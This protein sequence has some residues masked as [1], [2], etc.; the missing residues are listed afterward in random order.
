[1][2]TEKPGWDAVVPSGATGAAFFR[3][4][5]TWAGVTAASDAGAVAKQ[6][7]T[8][9]TAQTGN[10]NLTGTVV[11]GTITPSLLRGFPTGAAGIVGTATLGAGTVTV[12]TTAV[13]ASSII[14]ISRN[15]AGG[16]AGDLR[17]GAISA[18][19]NF[20]INSANGADT[21][22]INWLIIN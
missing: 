15:T 10:A 7:S 20:I 1:M 12:A 8:P 13:T 16:T 22:T 14:L 21:S 17:L 18:G 4:D 19:V 3:D 2:P 11:A 6:A 5:Y 9:G